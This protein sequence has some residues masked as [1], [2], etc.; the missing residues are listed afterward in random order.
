[1]GLTAFV[2]PRALPVSYEPLRLH[3]QARLGRAVEFYSARDFSAL[4]QRA[5]QPEQPF[6]MLP[7]HQALMVIEDAGLKLLARSTLGS[8]LGL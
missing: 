8:P 3:H 6:T 2:S 5:R 4:L 1:V 7:V